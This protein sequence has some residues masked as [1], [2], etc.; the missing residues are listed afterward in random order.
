M[1]HFVLVHGASHGAWCWYKV[2]T[3]L[4]SRG[5]NVTALDM[6]ASGVN[7]M[8]AHEVGSFS[9]YFEPL[10]GFM[11][12]LTADE[13]V[14]LVG[15]SVAGVG[16]CVAMESFCEKISVAVFLTA[17]M[18]GPDFS[19]K[20]M[21]KMR[22]KKSFSQA[23]V[24]YGYDNGPDNPPTS[25]ALST[26]FLKSNYYKLS[27]PEDFILATMLLRPFPVFANK[28]KQGETMFTKERYGSVRRVYLKC[29]EDDVYV[30][31]IMVENNPP[32]EVMV[33]SGADHMAMLSKPQELCSCLLEI[34][35][36][37]S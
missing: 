37:Y 9:D 24:K 2:M 7:P 5:H 14:I 34:A 29:E 19:C 30:Q 10:M 33:V 11:E 32:D 23:D 6:A 8:Q 27:P 21:D 31:G 3:L 12:S 4:K 17:A 26:N 1:K 20:A 36:K 18:P 13:R 15:H 22:A 16:I 25:V 35:D 28:G